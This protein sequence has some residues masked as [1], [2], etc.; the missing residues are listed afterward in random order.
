MKKIS[1][2]FIMLLLSVASLHAAAQITP[3]ALT[4]KQVNDWFQKR[5]WLAGLPL[6]PHASINKTVFARQYQLNKNYWDKAFAFLKEHDLATMAAGRYAIDGDN[7]YAIITENPTK[8]VDSAKWESHRNYIDLHLVIAGEEKI[9]VAD[10]TKLT[11]TM[12][13]DVTK[14][15]MNYSGD[16]NFYTAVPGTFFLF[17]PLD[18]HR[19]NIT[20][21]GN[22]PDKKIVIKIRYAE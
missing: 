3:T 18:A 16:G 6:Q 10:I 22:K 1:V 9:G 17:F 12:P 20:T 13:Y 4:K 11:V 8:V 2:Y 21:G 14:D 15:L 7:V 19:P 5:E